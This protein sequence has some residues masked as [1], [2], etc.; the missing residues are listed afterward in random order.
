MEREIPVDTHAIRFGE[1]MAD[2]I[3]VHCHDPEYTEQI[4]HICNQL[5]STKEKAI[6]YARQVSSI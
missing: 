3:I 2:W 4:H 1:A 5:F 6:Q